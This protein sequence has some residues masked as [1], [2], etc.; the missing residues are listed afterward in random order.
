MQWHW[1]ALV[2]AVAAGLRVRF[3]LEV[4][5]HVALHL[6]GGGA[7]RNNNISS[8]SFSIHRRGPHSSGT[9]RPSSSSSSPLVPQCA[10]QMTLAE[11]GHGPTPEACY[12]VPM[13]GQGIGILI[14]LIAPQIRT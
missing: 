1:A 7:R 2:T 13:G 12:S 8:S 9:P 14:L 4:T 10:A 3:L 11:T 6:Q 5:P